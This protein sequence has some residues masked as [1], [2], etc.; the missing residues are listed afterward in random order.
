MLLTTIF[1]WVVA[2][3]LIK[4]WVNNYHSWKHG[5]PLLFVFVLL[6]PMLWLAGIIGQTKLGEGCWGIHRLQQ[7]VYYDSFIDGVLGA[8]HVM[9]LISAVAI[10]LVLGSL[11][12][13][14]IIQIARLNFMKNFAAGQIPVALMAAGII[15]IFAPVGANMKAAGINLEPT[16]IAL[17]RAAGDAGKRGIEAV[18]DLADQAKT[19]S[20]KTKDQVQIPESIKARFEAEKDKGKN[21]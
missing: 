15:L 9:F 8:Y 16:Q 13:W 3:L 18:S 4:V 10:A 12:I 5:H 11:W 19:A 1:L 21:L 6:V 20:S 17:A 2:A 7:I 14:L